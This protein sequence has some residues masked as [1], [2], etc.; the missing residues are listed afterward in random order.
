MSKSRR[1]ATGFLLLA[2]TAAPAGEWQCHREYYRAEIRRAE[3]EAELDCAQ[4]AAQLER[5]RWRMN[6]TPGA[7]RMPY[8]PRVPAPPRRPAP[9]PAPADPPADP[10]A[11]R[12]DPS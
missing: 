12:G 7:I 1:L 11:S 5:Q 4:D 3:A 6:Q 10:P 2:A 9:A 8:R